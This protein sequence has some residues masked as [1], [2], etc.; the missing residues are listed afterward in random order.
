[1]IANEADQFVV[2]VRN[3]SGRHLME[4]LIHNITDLRSGFKLQELHRFTPREDKL[5]RLQRKLLCTQLSEQCLYGGNISSA[6]IRPARHS[7]TS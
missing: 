6:F 1:M 5:S 4:N 3:S 2:I 7:S